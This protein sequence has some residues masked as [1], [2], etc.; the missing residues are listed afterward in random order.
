MYYG[1]QTTDTPVYSNALKPSL[2]LAV[3]TNDAWFWI[4]FKYSGQH[5]AS[6]WASLLGGSD[7]IAYTADQD[8]NNAAPVD[9]ATDIGVSLINKLSSALQQ[10]TLPF[11]WTSAVMTAIDR[12]NLPAGQAM[13]RDSVSG[14]SAAIAANSTANIWQA[15]ATQ[16][17]TPSATRYNLQLYLKNIKT[18]NFTTRAAVNVGGATVNLST[19]T[20]SPTEGR[21]YVALGAEQNI[22]YPL[23][24][25]LKNSTTGDSIQLIFNMAIGQTLKIDTLNKKITYLL[26]KYD[27]FAALQPYPARDEWMRFLQ[28]V[29]NL[30]YTERGC[31]GVNIAV[32]HQDRNNSAG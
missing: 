28:G 13:F 25:T 23:N 26:D 1:D 27:A 7:A 21:P 2:D 12:F 31:T 14:N 11:G 30:V 18:V 29:N 3:S 16:T 15:V 6:S 19:L 4:N 32:I 24:A 10:I 17:F 22:T 8:L 20:T 5:G 9:P